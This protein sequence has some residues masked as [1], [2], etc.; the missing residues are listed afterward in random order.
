MKRYSAA[1]ARQRLADVLDAAERGEVVVIERRGIR[2]D[3]R[4]RPTKR[5]TKRRRSLI[6]HVDGAIDAGQWTW[7]PGPDGLEFVPRK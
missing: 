3:L 5:T 4:R 6:E 7:E 1:E 2:F